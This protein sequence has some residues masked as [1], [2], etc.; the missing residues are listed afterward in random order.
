M[1]RIIQGL[2]HLE[3]HSSL[4]FD[5]GSLLQ[6][7]FG[8]HLPRFFGL[9][10]NWGQWLE[11]HRRKSIRWFQQEQTA[12]T[13]AGYAHNVNLAGWWLQV[14]LPVYCHVSAPATVFRTHSADPMS[15]R[16]LE[17]AKPQWGTGWRGQWGHFR[18]ALLPSPDKQVVSFRPQVISSRVGVLTRV[19]HQLFGP[20]ES[21]EGQVK[22]LSSETTRHTWKTENVSVHRCILGR[23]QEKCN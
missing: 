10:V 18:K 19:Y 2:T 8:I 1:N 11:E 7:F 9:R 6:F 12:A 13:C 17:Q 14:P 16:R 3:V 5:N 15:P 22:S 4:L 21:L 23:F 20:V